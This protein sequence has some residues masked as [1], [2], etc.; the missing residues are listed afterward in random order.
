MEKVEK[1]W[2]ECIIFPFLGPLLMLVRKEGAG[3]PALYFHKTFAEYQKGFSA[4][5][6]LKRETILI[7]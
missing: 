6:L 3:N 1:S 7:I 5:G 2:A 4:N